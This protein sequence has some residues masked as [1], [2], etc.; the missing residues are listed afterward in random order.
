MSLALPF[1]LPTAGAVIVAALLTA[2]FLRLFRLDTATIGFVCRLIG[3]A[4]V[5][6]ILNHVLAAEA[7]FVASILCH[8]KLLVTPPLRISDLKA[9]RPSQ[10]DANADSKFLC[11]VACHID[12]HQYSVR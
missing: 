8:K 4:H 7:A 6:A 5:I 2:T 1:S 9:P 3:L 11:P 12:R 10:C